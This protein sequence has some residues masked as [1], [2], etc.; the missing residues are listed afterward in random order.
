[1]AA[2]WSDC[3]LL[4]GL[5]GAVGWWM[6]A[7]GPRRARFDV[8]QYRLAT[9]LTLACLIIT[10]THDRR[11]R[12]GDR[13]R[14]R[15]P[16]AAPA[17]RRHHGAAG[18]G[19]DL[20]RRA[21]CRTACRL[22]LQH[23]AADGR[24]DRAGRPAHHRSGLAQFLREPEDRAVRAPLVAYTRACGRALA[25]CSRR[26]SAP[27]GNAPMRAVRWCCSCWCWC[28]RRSASPRCWRRC[29]C[30]GRC[31]TRRSRWS[32]WFCRG[33]LARHQ[34]RVSAAGRDRRQKLSADRP[35][36]GSD[37]QLAPFVLSVPV[38]R[39]PGGRQ[40]SPGEG[41]VEN[42]P[43]GAASAPR[44]KSRP[45]GRYARGRGKDRR[46]RA[47]CRTDW[48]RRMPDRPECPSGRSPASRAVRG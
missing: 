22:E 11:A 19:A 32:C 3:W 21:G 38:F 17:L 45:Y 26:A 35:D 33:A 14:R 46:G 39:V 29:T 12:A 27:S 48:R 43:S 13:T 41:V 1:M 34:G 10:A 37:R 23:L 5:Q 44:Q 15:R 7:S 30:T 25:R 8:S 9:H 6:V 2:S 18:A 36:G 28:R 4:G 20:S 47:G 16:T 24:R 40:A 31:C 42:C